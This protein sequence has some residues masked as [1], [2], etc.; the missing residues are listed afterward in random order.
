MR[1]YCIIVSLFLILG[2]NVLSAQQARYWVT[3]TDLNDVPITSID[4]NAEFVMS[5]YTQDLRDNPSGVFALLYGATSFLDHSEISFETASLQIVPESNSF[6][7]FA[8]GVVFFA[9]LRQRRK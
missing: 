5:V 1:A 9:G 3:L 7:L 6:S 4:Q 8:L 2:S